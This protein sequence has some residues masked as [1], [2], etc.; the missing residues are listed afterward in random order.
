MGKRIVR[1]IDDGLPERLDG[2]VPTS[3]TQQGDPHV[4]AHIRI[5]GFD[6]ERTAIVVDRFDQPASVIEDQIA[7]VDEAVEVVGVPVQPIE[8]VLLQQFRIDSQTPKR[9]SV[10]ARQRP[11]QGVDGTGHV[12]VPGREREHDHQK[13]R[14]GA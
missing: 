9:D 5:V 7:Q 1:L 4:G 11:T 2:L 10:Y 3:Q 12:E 14:A 13:L 6:G 8:V